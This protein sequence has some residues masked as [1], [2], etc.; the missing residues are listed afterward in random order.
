VTL[1][2]MMRV[3]VGPAFERQM[4]TQMLDRGRTLNGQKMPEMALKAYGSVGVINPMAQ[5]LR[6]ADTLQLTAVQADSIAVLNRMYTIK[7]DSVWTPVAKYLST[8]PDHYDHGEAYDRYKQARE[9]S[10][11]AL[12]KAAPTV[13]GLL[14]DA[15]V[16]MLP[17]FITPFLDQRYL[18]SIRSG[19]SG[20]NLGM[21]M[22]PGGA[23]AMGAAMGGG[24]GGGGMQVIIKSGTP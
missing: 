17:T 15:Q 12:I 23:A 24:M 19:T 8:L 2:A 18:S 22:M 4:L 14:T 13:K 11:D 20:S 16:R 10:V 9:M 3:D 21:I 5:I 6:Q 7:L 1:T